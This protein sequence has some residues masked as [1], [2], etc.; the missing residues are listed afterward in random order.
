VAYPFFFLTLNKQLARAAVGITAACSLF[1]ACS[2]KSSSAPA[3]GDDASTGTGAETGAPEDAAAAPVTPCDAAL[4]LPT[5]GGPGTAC[6]QCIETNCATDLTTCQ[7]DCVCQQSLECL[8]PND[9]NYTLCMNNALPAISAGDVGLM[10]V[11]ACI[12][13]KCNAICNGGGDA[14]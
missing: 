6:G 2:S 14:N 9:N 5:D 7:M 11:A 1:L 8:V 13:N 12:T 10:D 3:G 4:S